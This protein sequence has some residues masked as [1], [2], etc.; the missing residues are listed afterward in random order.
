MANYVSK[1]IKI[2]EAE[3]G[4]MEKETN[5][6]LDSKTANAGDE[7]YTKYA[8]DLDNLTDFY[9][10]KKNGYSWCDV[11]VDWCFYKAFGRTAAQTLL[12]QPNKSL[13]AGCKYSAL[14]FKG[15]NQFYSSPKVGDQIFFKKTDGTIYHTGLVYKVDKTYVYTIEGNTSSAEG[16]V[17]N[18]GCVAKKKYKLGYSKIAGYGRPKYDTKP[19]V[20]YYKKYTG[21]STKIDVVFKA[22]GA[23][24]GS[25][26]K[27]KPVA[28]KN[29]YSSYSGTAAQNL[30][31]INKAKTGKLIK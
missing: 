5:K 4:Y 1:L 18:G 12:C 25:V 22:V 6:N 23:P 14:Y 10:G 31:L 19:T 27:R 21:T 16:V 24:Y 3:V 30:A 13:G 29:G 2:A 26:T 9:N 8:R 7:N 15:K 20:T 17:E 28:K 11:F